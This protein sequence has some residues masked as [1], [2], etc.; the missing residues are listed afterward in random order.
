MRT[1]VFAR[2]GVVL[3]LEVI[4]P[5]ATLLPF[6]REEVCVQQ[7]EVRAVPILHLVGMYVGM[8]D[9]QVGA[10]AEVDAVETGGEGE[11]RRG[12]PRE[13]EVRAELLFIQ[14]VEGLLILLGP[15]APVPGL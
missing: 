12:D 14:L 13:L 8:I 5:S 7:A 6:T 2:G 3:L 4:H 10:L 1:V 11:D 15:V 9:G